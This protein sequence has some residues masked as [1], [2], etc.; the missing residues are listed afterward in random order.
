MPLL[1]GLLLYFPNACA[2]VSHVSARAN[3]QHNPGEPMHWAADKSIGTGNEIVRH[4]LERGTL[5]SD[6]LRHT[7]KAAWRVLELLER[8]LLNGDPSLKPGLNS[9]NFTRES[10]QQKAEK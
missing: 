8:E 2:Y 5:D 1:D 3:E 7:G 4:L 9:K 6:G 10:A